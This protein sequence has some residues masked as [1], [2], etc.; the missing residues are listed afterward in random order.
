[1]KITNIYTHFELVTTRYWD[2]RRQKESFTDL[3]TALAVWDQQRG[4]VFHLEEHSDLNTLLS[5][6]R[7]EMYDSSGLRDVLEFALYEDHS[8]SVEQRTSLPLERDNDAWC[9]SL[10]RTE[11]G[12]WKLIETPIPRWWEVRRWADGQITFPLKW[13]GE[14][15]S[16]WIQ[17]APPQVEST[18]MENSDIPF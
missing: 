7:L 10:E 2:G 6:C 16:W 12:P 13:V 4:R 14:Q 17:P 11:S 1:M 5:C 18:V 9:P 15:P 8:W 3:A